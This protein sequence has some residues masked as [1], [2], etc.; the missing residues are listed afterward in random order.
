MVPGSWSRS[1]VSDTKSTAPQS[2]SSGGQGPGSAP[3]HTGSTSLTTSSSLGRAISHRHTTSFTAVMDP[4]GLNIIEDYAQLQQLSGLPEEQL[5]QQGSAPRTPAVESN[6]AEAGD[7]APSGSAA[8]GRSGSALGSLA[9]A[10]ASGVSATAGHDSSVAASPGT[11]KSPAGS[12]SSSPSKASSKAGSRMALAADEHDQGVVRPLLT[13]DGEASQCRESEQDTAAPGSVSRSVADES[14][15]SAEKEG[16]KRNGDKS[17]RTPSPPV[18]QLSPRPRSA[19]KIVSFPKDTS[20]NSLDVDKSAASFSGGSAGKMER[21]LARRSA[22]P[23]LYGASGADKTGSSSPTNSRPG[24]RTSMREGLIPS[25]QALAPGDVGYVVPGEED[26][27]EVCVEVF[28]HERVQPFRGWGH[29]WPG[30]FLPSDKVRQACST[31]W[32]HQLAVW[33]VRT[34]RLHSSKA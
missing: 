7:Q 13:A 26:D 16:P 17:Q 32:R 4:S 3:D 11:S 2:G 27:D 31:S 22:S 20:N 9:A 10:A 34:D 21:S 12:R 19:G 6:T 30:H 15:A 24:S 33:L 14:P 23:L 29:T 28:E 25:Y 5:E 8:D 18:T 1:A